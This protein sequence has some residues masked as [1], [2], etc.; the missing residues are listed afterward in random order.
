MVEKLCT[1]N[2]SPAN[3]NEELKL[4]NT[5][6]TAEYKEIKLKNDTP[7]RKLSD[8]E[9]YSVVN[10]IE[11]KGIL[12]TQD[13]DCTLIIQM[14]GD[15]IGCPVSP[16]DLDTALQPKMKTE[17]SLPGST[18][19]QRKQTSSAECEKHGFASKM[20]A[21]PEPLRTAQYMTMTT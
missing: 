11:I 12:C 17:T 6:L 3:E 1:E 16:L 15:N 21:F 19:K 7:S 10:N 13:E 5:S 9:P 8:L 4:Q 18:L 20:L 14:V 2:A